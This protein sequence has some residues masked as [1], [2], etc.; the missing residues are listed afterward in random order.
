M[1]NFTTVLKWLTINHHYYY[2]IITFIS[3]AVATGCYNSF[4]PYILG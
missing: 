3:I 4:Y 2:I 1:E